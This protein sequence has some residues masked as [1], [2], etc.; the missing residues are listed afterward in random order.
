MRR[1][2]SNSF[3]LFITSFI[4]T[5]ASHSDMDVTEPHIYLEAWSRAARA[6]VLVIPSTST[7]LALN[8]HMR[9]YAARRFR[10]HRAINSWYIFCSCG[11]S[12]FLRA[13]PSLHRVR[14][15]PITLFH[16]FPTSSDFPL[17]FS[18]PLVSESIRSLHVTRQI[19]IEV[20]HSSTSDSKATLARSEVMSSF[21]AS[22]ISS[23][24]SASASASFDRLEKSFR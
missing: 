3:S 13:S 14:I 12:C 18:S 6:A 15:S 22:L 21:I 23:V 5:V 4:P 7:F 16:S 1:P 10:F 19:R 2:A 11:P 17:K 9:L 24:S 20:S 8:Q